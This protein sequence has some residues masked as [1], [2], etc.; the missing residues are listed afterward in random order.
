MKRA[1]IL[2]LGILFLF[3]NYSCSNENDS[4]K[5]PEKQLIV[6]LAS[7]IKLNPGETEVV[8]TDYFPTN[9]KIDSIKA[10]A[11]IKIEID[12]SHTIILSA[13]NNEIPKISVLHVF[14][15][16]SRYDIL[17]KKSEKIAYQ[18]KYKPQKVYKVIQLK[19]EFNAWN[20]LSTTLKKD[21]DTY[22][23]TLTMEPGEYQYL[24]V[25]DGK[26]MIDYQNHDS[27]SN[28]MVGFNS[29]LKIGRYKDLD[30]PHLFAHNASDNILIINAINNIENLLVFCQN[31]LLP[32]QYIA[33]HDNRIE[34]K[35]PEELAK[36][37]RSYIRIQATNSDGFSNFLTIPLDNGRVI[38]SAKRLTRTDFEAATLYNVFVDRF[39]DGNKQNTW[40]VKDKRILPK[41]NY[42]GGDLEGIIQKIN[43]GYF[44]NLGIN[45]LWISPLVKNPE[46][47]FGMY[48]DPKTSFSGYHGYWPISFTQINPHFGTREDLKK[49]VETA[50]ASN[51]NV[52]LDFVSNHVHQD[53]PIIKKHPDWKTN[54]YLPDGTLNTEKWDSHRLTTWFDVFLPT[55]NLEKP[56]VTDML[57]DS[58]VWWIKEYNLDG[59]RHD[60]TKH[61]PEIFWRTLT[62]KL[63][64]K[65]VIPEHRRLY[66][67][68]ETYGSP[69]L[70][71][72]YVNS[73]QL[74]AQFDF[75]VYDAIVSTLAGDNSFENLVSEILKSQKYYGSHHLMGNITGN[76]DRARFISYASGAL[77]FTEDAKKAGWQRDIEVKDP[78][79][80]KKSAMLDAI[81]ATLPGVPVIYYGD[82]I[83]MPGGNDPDNRRMMR[84]DSLS[85][86]EK[87]LKD[88]TCKIL[89]FRRKALPLIFGDIQIL[90]VTPNILVYERNYLNQFVIVALNK[91]NADASISIK[92]RKDLK[93]E[94]PITLF[95][96]ILTNGKNTLTVAIPANNFEIITNIE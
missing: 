39:Y 32:K 66:Q 88:I 21:G 7:P 42:F 23:T 30:K 13:E 64:T 76:Q 91:S 18:Y 9:P 26:E 24:I 37:K 84:F 83:G 95:G 20:P 45:T 16:G 89:N 53:H 4:F 80:Y 29:V 85:E 19:G 87:K 79:G 54:L 11:S 73:G 92:K 77:K 60:A 31:R 78:V 62:Q 55:L 27:I 28:G 52:L 49:L 58:A 3:F 82:E 33:L 8:L 17:I 22:K 43:D 35:I 10:S 2:L 86:Q 65:V 67:I 96:S 15:E 74:D 71:G 48:P 1:G 63:R 40:T 90:Q 75:N 68:G 6:G 44:S 59:F 38:T 94:S 50:H 14:T 41:A 93:I 34:V 81:I 57:T 72:S 51:M 12:T 70:I 47:A 25:A 5:L 36:L 46:K 69:E 61:V 56:E